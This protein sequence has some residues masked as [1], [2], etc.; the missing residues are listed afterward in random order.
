VDRINAFGGH[1]PNAMGVPL[2][3]LVRSIDFGV[4]KINIDTDTRLGV[5]GVIREVFSKQPDK[6]DPRDYL[7]PAMEEITRIVAERMRAFRTAGHVGDY[8]PISLDDM[9]KTYGKK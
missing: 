9:K 2:A 4:R 3:D 6:F 7:K 8:A 5:T 1:M